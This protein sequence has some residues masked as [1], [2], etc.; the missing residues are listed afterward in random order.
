LHRATEDRIEIAKERRRQ[1][2]HG[3]R[4]AFHRA[5]SNLHCRT[6][7][8]AAAQP[9]PN[10]PSE[11]LREKGCRTFARSCRTLQIFPLVGARGTRLRDNC[12]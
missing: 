6:P 10:A 8:G 9:P 2:M 1:R 4:D 12:S 3:A 11:L 5:E 7:S